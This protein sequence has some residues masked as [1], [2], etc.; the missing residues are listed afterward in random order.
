MPEN[1]KRADGTH[2][3]QHRVAVLAIP[4]CAEWYELDQHTPAGLRPAQKLC[5]RCGRVTA[6]RDP[7]GLPWCGGEPVTVDE[8]SPAPKR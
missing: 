3:Q 2:Y 6:R 1:A 7:A 5:T 8:A 4:P